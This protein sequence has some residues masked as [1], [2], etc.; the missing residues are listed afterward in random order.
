MTILRIKYYIGWK[1]AQ[2][3]VTHC[4]LSYNPKIVEN[5][6]GDEKNSI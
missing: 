2:S 5:Q 4:G 1:M 6:Q 3:A